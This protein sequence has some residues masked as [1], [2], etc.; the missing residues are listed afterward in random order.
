MLGELGFNTES[1]ADGLSG[2][3]SIQRRRPDLVLS[4][5]KMPIMD[6]FETIRELRASPELRTLPIVAFSADVTPENSA[7][8][9]EA[10]ADAFVGCPFATSDLMT[11]LKDGL[12]LEWTSSTTID[13]SLRLQSAAAV[14]PPLEQLRQ[15][16]QLAKAGNMRAIRAFLNDLTDSNPE[17]GPYADQ[18]K[19]LT[20]AYQSPAILTLVSQHINAREAA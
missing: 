5:L 10:G 1:A 11:V 6:G 19:R 20:E 4:G 17:Y 15:L 9:L 18:M 12:G 3:Q 7:R 8:A 16:N 14:V 2:L 13:L